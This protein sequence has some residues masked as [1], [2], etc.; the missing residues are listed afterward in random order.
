[1]WATSRVSSSSRREPRLLSFSTPESQRK[2][3]H[4]RILLRTDQSR[5][6]P[7]P[8]TQKINC[9]RYSSAKVECRDSFLL[10]PRLPNTLRLSLV[11]LLVE[12]VDVAELLPFSIEFGPLLKGDTGPFSARASS[13]LPPEV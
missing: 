12:V 1:M 7:V 2:L 10:H 8:R 11:P 5:A 6:T 9:P 13:D 4:H 3:L